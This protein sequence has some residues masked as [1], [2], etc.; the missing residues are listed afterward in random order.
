MNCIICGSKCSYFFSKSYVDTEFYELMHDIGLVNYYKC[1][2]CGFVLSKTHADMSDVVWSKLN[3]QFHHLIENRED[4]SHQPPYLEQALMISILG[5][6]KIIDL[7]SM[8]D[9]AAGYGTLSKILNK[10]CKIQLPIYDPHVKNKAV[11]K[12]VEKSELSTYKTVIN[13]AMFEHVISRKNLDDINNLC[14]LDGALI[15]HTVICEN[16]PKDPNWFYLAPP[17]HTAFHTNKS[18]GI[19]MKQ[20][21]Y[22]FSIY[23]PP[24]KCW[25]LLRGDL[26]DVKSKL[27]FINKEFQ[28]EWFFCKKGFVDYWKGF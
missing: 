7:S 15:I 9:Y 24:S 10:Y 6:N 17:V 19:L 14:D 13:S 3:N 22:D 25:I 28:S 20:W 5:H 21:G 1:D 18:M 27:W 16:I 26:E 23:C 2:N 11:D 4:K 12:Y 8:L